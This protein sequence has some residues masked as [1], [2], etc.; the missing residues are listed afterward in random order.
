MSLQPFLNTLVKYGKI[1]ADEARRAELWDVPDQEAL[2]ERLLRAQMI[3]EPALFEVR[4]HEMGLDLCD[5]LPQVDALPALV[6]ELPPAFMRSRRLIPIEE[7]GDL[8]KAASD[9]LDTLER[10]GELEFM[11]TKRVQLV[12]APAAAIDTLLAQ[13]FRPDKP[14]IEPT[15]A[16]KDQIPVTEVFEQADESP[17]AALLTSY[18]SRAIEE[19]A[20]D[21]H[22][23]PKESGLSVRF[24]IDGALVT[25][26][27]DYPQVRDQILTRIRVLAGLDIAEHR[28]AQDGRIQFPVGARVVD[29]R[30]SVIPTANGQRIVLRI[31]D[32]SK[33]L[34]D[35][36][37]LGM[38]E[39]MLAT[40]KRLITKSEGIVLVTGPTG[41]G[42]TTSLYCALSEVNVESVNIMTIEDPI[43]Y[44]L[45]GISQMAVRPEIGMT[46]AEGLR[47]LLRQ[48]PDVLMVG[49]IRDSETAKVAIQAALTGHLVL[50]TLH[51]NDAP[52]AVTRLVEMG[53]ESYLLSSSLVGVLAQRLVRTICPGCRE[54]YAPSPSE[55]NDLGIEADTLWRGAGCSSCFGTGYSGRRAIFELLEITPALRNMIST[56]SDAD[57]LASFAKERGMQ[58]LLQSGAALVLAGETTSTEVIGVVG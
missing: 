40:F 13:L 16:K 20:S 36:A 42:K 2:V 4:A 12:Y 25:R 51:T 24:R 9:R 37:S 53:V 55:L 27:F 22:F 21:I 58:T 50:S 31:L 33:M 35:T 32:K 47:H 5:E 10:V 23:E 45:E 49:E 54:S 3:T 18:I 19:G 43:E 17:V 28:L 52:S 34:L 39:P 57:K 7:S 29:L 56:T 44:R 8:V 46:F 11:L 1:T 26:P 30:V 15:R 41:S 38:S 14:A 6:K 48:D